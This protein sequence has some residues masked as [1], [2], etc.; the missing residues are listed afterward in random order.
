MENKELFTVCTVLNFDSDHI[1][2][3]L[4][5]SSLNIQKTKMEKIPM[6]RIFAGLGGCS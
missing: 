6:G 4:E 1:R 5:T 2:Y 3:I